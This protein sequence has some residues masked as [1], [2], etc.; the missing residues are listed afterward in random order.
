MI[1]LKSIRDAVVVSRSK[2]KIPGRG[3]YT[4]PT[5]DCAKSALRK[6]RLSRALRKNITRFPS[7]EELLTGL[8]EKR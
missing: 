1:H 8:D 5:Q 4:C 6:E 3:C 2:D 7:P